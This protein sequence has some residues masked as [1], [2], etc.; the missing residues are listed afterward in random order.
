VGFLLGSSLACNAPPAADPSDR[1]QT[2]DNPRVAHDSPGSA[3]EAKHL[4]EG[5]I[6]DLG[7]RGYAALRNASAETGLQR[8]DTLS[9]EAVTISHMTA[10]TFGADGKTEVTTDQTIVD[11]A[12]KARLYDAEA[13]FSAK[14]GE[15]LSIRRIH[16]RLR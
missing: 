7:S 16:K 2:R 11:F 1:A 12:L 13:T 8:S 14:T 9:I 4:S 5:E 15:L 6:R 3:T 10:N